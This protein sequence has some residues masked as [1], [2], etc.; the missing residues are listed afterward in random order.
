MVKKTLTEFLYMPGLIPSLYKSGIFLARVEE[1]LQK[2][3][4]EDLAIPIVTVSVN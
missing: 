4:G 3:I 1:E 2:R